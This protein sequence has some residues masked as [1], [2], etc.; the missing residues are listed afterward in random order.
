M[1][2]ET[3]DGAV[4]YLLNQLRKERWKAQ[5]SSLSFSL[6]ESLFVSLD[7][8]PLPIEDSGIS[9]PSSEGKGPG[10]LDES[11]IAFRYRTDHY[12]TQE[13]AG[14]SDE[15]GGEAKQRH[16]SVPEYHHQMKG[17]GEEEESRGWMDGFVS[18]EIVYSK[19][20]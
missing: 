2:P 5:V 10:F 7:W 1:E 12:T 20:E 18:G 14:E 9:L 11:L 13:E 16:K 6:I 19:I 4:L 8:T 17:M 3:E 15:D